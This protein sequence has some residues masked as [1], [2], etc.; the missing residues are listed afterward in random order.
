MPRPLL[1]PRGTFIPTSWIYNRELSAAVVLTWM[2]LRGLA[3]GGAQTPELN[4]KQLANLTGK[5]S[6]TLYGHMTLLRNRGAL[7]WHSSVKG[8][9]IITFEVEETSEPQEAVSAAFQDSKNLEK[10]YPPPLNPINKNQENQEEGGG[11]GG[12]QESGTDSRDLESDPATI[13]RRLTRIQPNPSQLHRLAEQV[14]NP[15][16][17]QL[18]LEHWLEHHWNPNNLPGLLDFYSRGGPQHCKAC[19]PKKLSTSV[20]AIERLGERLRAEQRELD[21]AC[22]GADPGDL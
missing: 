4:I 14:H 1:P 3:W 21:D 22:A 2:Q 16:L 18:S 15:R 11:G 6:S 20:E 13:Y 10:P 19:Q 9:F 5:S 17:W 8:T 12:I 7:R